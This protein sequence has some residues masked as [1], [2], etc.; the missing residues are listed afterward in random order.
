MAYGLDRD[1]EGRL[2]RWT[3][4]GYVPHVMTGIAWGHYQ[5]ELNT[6]FNQLRD[7]KQTRIHWAQA[8]EGVGVFLADSAMFQRAEPAFRLGTD[9]GDPDATQATAEEIRMFSGFYGLALPPLKHGIPIR[10]VQ[11]DNVA[12]FPG[13]LDPYRGLLLSYEF[14]KPRQP[15]LH[16]AL[17]QWVK[18]GGVLIYA[19]A[20]T[21]PFNG[22]REWW[23]RQPKV[24][25]A[26]SEHLFETLGLPPDL[27]EGT[28]PCGQGRVIVHRVHP[29]SFTRSADHMRPLMQS[30]QQAVTF[31]GH[32]YIERNYFLLRRGPYVLAACLNESVSEHPLCIEGRFINL[33]DSRLAVVTDPQVPPGQQAWFLDLDAIEGD[34]PLAL[35]AAGRIEQWQAEGKSL[36]YAISSPDQIQVVTRLWLPAQP[37]SVSLNRE[38]CRFEW[39]AVSKTLFISHAGSSDPLTVEVTW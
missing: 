32:A 33:L 22:V 19:G 27:H 13:Y 37:R 12:R 30:I 9:R 17:A 21:D 35:A 36:T 29:A 10:P 20:D 25:A 28:H 2:Q 4:A 6:V 23:N 31:T 24:F 11:L 5:E 7:M 1:M 38:P 15:G 39:D 16:L 3:E 34:P 26:P 14:L 18:A 8:T